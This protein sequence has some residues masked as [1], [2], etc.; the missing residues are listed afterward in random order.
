MTH[1]N[2]NEKVETATVQTLTISRM[3]NAPREAVWK[4]WTEPERIKKWWG[5]KPFTAPAARVDLRVGGKYVFDMRSPDG[6][7]Y[8]STGIYREIK[9][10]E[11]IVATDSF[12]DEKGNV[13]PATK[14]GFKA[15]F[16]AELLLTT[17]FE[18]VD[19]KTKLTL[20][21]EGFPADQVEGAREGWT[22]SL[23]KL[24][25]SLTEPKGGM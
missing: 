18:E 21:H 3:I 16:P 17:T 5:P 11:R 4:A 20:R 7:D 25:E 8:W 10:M 22:T 1:H 19:G 6:K 23:E 2:K 12:A 13:V 15:D 14:Y 24:E 9:P